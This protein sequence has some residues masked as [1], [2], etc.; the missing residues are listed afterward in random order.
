MIGT[1]ITSNPRAAYNSALRGASD[2]QLTPITH[3]TAGL[4]RALE[5][6]AGLLLGFWDFGAEHIVKF[7]PTQATNAVVNSVTQ[8]PSVARLEWWVA[9][10]VLAGY[11]AVLAGF[12]IW[13]TL[14]EDVS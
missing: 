10:L 11:A 2:D 12:G 5:A 7:L 1:V 3:A 14:H 9:A 8:G 13:R 6:V 4:P